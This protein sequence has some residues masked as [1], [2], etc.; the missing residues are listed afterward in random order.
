MNAT[1]WIIVAIVAVIIVAV[2]LAALAVSRRRARSAQL[3]DRF[4]PEYDRTVDASGDQRT[5]ERE[6]AAR[7]DRHDQIE[8]HD[9]DPSRREEFRQQWM[10]V[11]TA[12]VDD[13]RSAT[14]RAATLVHDAMLARGYPDGDRATLIDMMSVDHPDLVPEYRR[15]HEA[16]LRG[17]NGDSDTEEFRRTVLRYR[18]VF[19]RVLA[20]DRSRA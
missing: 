8:L 14:D 19:D 12:F 6:L 5:A 11:Q 3:R 1:A 13:P 16:T 17:R 7:L 9:I 15:A 4:G 2:V 10:R 18:T 20:G